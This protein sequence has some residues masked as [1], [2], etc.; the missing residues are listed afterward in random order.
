MLAADYDNAYKQ[1]LFDDGA[2]PGNS[3]S[4]TPGGVEG[5]VPMGGGRSKK[6]RRNKSRKS[7][8]LKQ[9]TGGKKH[10]KS[11]RRMKKYSRKH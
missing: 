5:G 4:W 10:R 11:M 7:K 8:K 1:A 2:G 6:L 3:P 9:K